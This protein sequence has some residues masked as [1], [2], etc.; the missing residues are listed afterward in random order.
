M[1]KNKQTKCPISAAGP[2][3]LKQINT[4]YHPDYGNWSGKVM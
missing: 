3:W 1:I 2:N 4:S